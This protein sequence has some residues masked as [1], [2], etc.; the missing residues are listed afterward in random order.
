MKGHFSQRTDFSEDLDK[1]Y[2]PDVYLF[3]VFS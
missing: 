3:V 1:Q 2:F